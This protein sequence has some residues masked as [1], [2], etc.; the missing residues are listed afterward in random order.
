MA[1]LTTST[2]DD[3]AAS[4][5]SSQWALL[6]LTYLGLVRGLVCSRSTKR[7]WSGAVTL[8]VQILSPR[9]LGQV[10]ARA[11][12]GGQCKWLWQGAKKR[13]GDI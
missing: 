9:T 12:G 2:V 11:R 3:A 13:W 10:D 7:W 6:G 5:L 4:S 8:Y 1:Y